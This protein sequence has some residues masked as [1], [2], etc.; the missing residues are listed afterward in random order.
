MNHFIVI[1]EDRQQTLDLYVYLLG[2]AEGFRPD[3]G[4]DGP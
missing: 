4:F 1:A 3:L 2:L